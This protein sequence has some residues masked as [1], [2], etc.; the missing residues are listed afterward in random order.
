MPVRYSIFLW[1]QGGFALPGGLFIF[2]HCLVDV[3]LGFVTMTGSLV[4]RLTGEPFVFF[5][6]PLG[7]LVRGATPPTLLALLTGGIVGKTIFLC[8]VAA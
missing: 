6:V 5:S 7:E 4:L 2:T 3:F 1:F 8:L